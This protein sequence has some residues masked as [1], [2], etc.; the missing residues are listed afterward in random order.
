M[1]VKVCG[2][3]SIEELEFVERYADFAGVV[4]DSSSKRFVDYGV[5]RE[6]IEVASI[7]VFAVLTCSSFDDACRTAGKINAECLQIHSGIFPVSDFLM[8]KDHGFRLI[9]AFRIPKRSRDFRRDAENTV[10][11]IE[12]YKPDFALLD[13]GRGTGELHD[14]RVSREVAKVERVILAGGLNPGNVRSA[15]EFVKPIGVD[16]SGGVERNGRK[17]ESLVR[18][19]VKNVKAGISERVI[20]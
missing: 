14:L 15:V 3:R 2:I 12:Q 19:F 13:T 16:V 20:R 7:P 17:D 1:I 10:R 9:K 6:I 4:M 11:R 18:R 5:A 8:L